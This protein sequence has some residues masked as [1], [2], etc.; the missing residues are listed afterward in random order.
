MAFTVSLNILII[1]DEWAMTLLSPAGRGPLMPHSWPVSTAQSTAQCC[2]EGDTVEADPPL[3][4]QSTSPSGC[5]DLRELYTNYLH[6]QI[7]PRPLPRPRRGQTLLEK[8]A[9]AAQTEKGDKNQG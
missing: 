9:D 2:P 3:C 8:R 5:S 4:S 1:R 6:L 7:G